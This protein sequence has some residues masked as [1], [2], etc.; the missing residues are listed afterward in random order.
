MADVRPINALHY[1]LGMVGSLDDVAAPPYDVIDAAQRARAAGALALQRGRDRP[2][3]T[4]RRAGPQQTRGRS[5]R[6]GGA[7]DRRLARGGRAGRRRRAGDLGDDPGLHRPRRRQPHPP[8]HP[9]PGPGRGLRRPAR[10]SP[11][12]AP[13]PGPKQ[14]RLDLTRATRHNL[15]PIFSLSTEDAWP[16]VEPALDR[17]EPWGEATDEGG[18]VN[19]VWRVGDPAIHA[20]VTELLAG[21]QLLI[22]DGHHRY[23]TAIAYRDEVGGEGAAQLHAD[24]ADRARRPRPHRLPHPPPALRLRRR[25]RAPAAPRRAACAS[26]STSTEVDA[27]ASSTRAA[28]TASASSASTTPSTSSAFRLR[29]KDTRSPRSTAQLAGKP[30]AYRRLDSAILETLVLKGIAG[31]SEDDILAKRGLGY[32]KSVEDSLALLDDGAYDVAFILR[33]IPVDQVRA[34]CRNRREHAAEVDLLLP[35][36][37]D[38]ARLQPGRLSAAA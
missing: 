26:C 14:D 36:G 38:R 18:T 5:L 27:R 29:L 17:D 2:A 4:V 19:R 23:E 37:D 12:S 30:E 20:A 11:T 34:I 6:A 25:P 3:E 33:P 21:A 16:L 15:S 8:R 32:A 31:M 13:C 28:R 1:D 9:R 35:Q 10:S 24:G 7:D 22:A